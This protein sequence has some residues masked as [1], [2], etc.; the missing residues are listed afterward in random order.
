MKN[1]IRD[2]LSRP[3]TQPALLSLLKLCHAGLNYGGGQM[4]A[5]SGEIGAL[6]FLG[7]RRRTPGS[8]VLFD[9]GANQGE[10]LARALGNL[11]PDVRA[12]SFEPQSAS[13]QNLQ[14]RFAGDDRVHLQKIALGKETGTAELF[15]EADLARTAS[16]YPS[17]L[18]RA[19]HSELVNV[20][21][22]DAVC[23]EKKIHHI[24]LLKI[25][26]EG[27][28]MD[29]LLGASSALDCDRIGAIQFE[30]GDSFVHT[31]YHF[32][33]FWELLSQRYDIYR[34]LRHGM[35]RVERYTTD[36]EIYKTANLLCVLKVGSTRAAMPVSRV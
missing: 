11:G 27:H 29:V 13:F 21:T 32:L 25:D 23:K 8:F 31:Q 10:Y 19:S 12:Y 35:A 20:S 2:C 22:V 36:L 24:D 5:H 17:G 28:D 30:F 26:T 15:F 6:E 16:L 9:V 33:D 34:I 14:G 18:K 1:A 3:W 7:E 4:V